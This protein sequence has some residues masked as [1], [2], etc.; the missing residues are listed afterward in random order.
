VCCG[1]GCDPDSTPPDPD[2]QFFEGLIPDL[3]SLSARRK[4]D[5]KF[6]IHQLIFEATCQQLD[7][8]V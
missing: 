6:K 7:E 5:V 2:R 4:A 1:E 8:D 3:K